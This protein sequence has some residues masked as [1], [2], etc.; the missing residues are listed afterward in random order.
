M[1]ISLS[2]STKSAGGASKAPGI[3]SLLSSEEV[4]A[5]VLFDDD[6]E[7][8]DNRKK[9]LDNFKETYNQNNVFTLRDLVSSTPQHSTMEDMMP[10]DYVKSF[11]ETELST[12]FNIDSSKAIILQLK[13][14]SEDL[15]DKQKLESLKVKLSKKFVEDFATKNKIENDAPR[16]KELIDQLIIK[17]TQE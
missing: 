9:I 1:N 16:I 15:K 7:G 2:Y 13:Q 14:Q 11:F 12:T 17:W 3:A 8:R 10:V 6:K 5:F 4:P